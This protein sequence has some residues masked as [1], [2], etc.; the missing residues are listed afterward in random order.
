MVFNWFTV[1][2]SLTVILLSAHYEQ[3]WNDLFEFWS[4]TFTSWPDIEKDCGVTDV[5]REINSSEKSVHF[6]KDYVLDS[7]PFNMESSS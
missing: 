3:I 2:H 7:V 1:G 4:T 5:Q 6:L